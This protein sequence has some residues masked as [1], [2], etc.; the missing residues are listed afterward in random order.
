MIGSLPL[1]FAQPLVLLGLGEPP[2]R[3]TNLGIG[4]SAAE[5]ADELGKELAKP[6]AAE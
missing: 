3:E 4:V 5:T 6:D 1:A 2:E